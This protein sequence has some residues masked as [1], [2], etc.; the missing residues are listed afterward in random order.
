M[1]KKLEDTEQLLRVQLMELRQ[2]VNELKEIVKSTSNQSKE[3]PNQQAAQNFGKIFAK[4][5]IKPKSNEDYN[6]QMIEAL[7]KSFAYSIK[8]AFQ[9][10]NSFGKSKQQIDYQQMQ[11]FKNMSYK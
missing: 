4:M 3:F 11:N 10:A 8:P 1:L 9:S 7:F 6:K 5:M 2:E